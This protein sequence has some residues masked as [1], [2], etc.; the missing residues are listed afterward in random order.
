MENE[1]AKYI[2][3]NVTDSTR[4]LLYTYDKDGNFR[5]GCRLSRG[6]RPGD[7]SAGLGPVQRTDRRGQAESDTPG[8]AS[9]ILYYMEKNLLIPM[10]LSMHAGISLWRVKISPEARILFKDYLKRP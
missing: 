5:E 9:P 3:T 6:A 8:K 1:S 2:K 7:P 10:D 4:E